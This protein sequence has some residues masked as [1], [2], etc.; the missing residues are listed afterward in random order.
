MESLGL[1]Y[2]KVVQMRHGFTAT[3]SSRN[4][5]NGFGQVT[6]LIQSSRLVVQVNI[7]GSIVE[8]DKTITSPSLVVYEVNFGDPKAH[9]RI[10]RIEELGPT[11]ND[12]SK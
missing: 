9:W 12:V 2:L 8:T 1:F 10:A 3:G 4:R 11:N 7:D 5:G 6:A